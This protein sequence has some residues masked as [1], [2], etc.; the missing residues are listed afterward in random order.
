[1]NFKD[2]TQHFTAGLVGIYDPD[3]AIAIFSM[4]ASHVVGWDRGRLMFNALQEVP[5]A[6]YLSFLEILEEL[7]TGKPIQYVLGE[8]VF[9]G[10]K[11]KVSP[12]VLIPRPETEELVE[13]VIQ[14]A[15]SSDGMAGRSVQQMRIL[16]IGTGSGCIA[17][18]LKKQLPKAE[19]SALDVSESAIQI[20]S[21]NAFIN[22][23]VV[24]FIEADIR[25]YSTTG[26]F[27]I[28][29]SN[30]P[31]ITQK[32]KEEMQQNVLDHEPH[33][34]LFVTNE[35]PL[36]FYKAIADF[37]LSNL[38]P[39][40]KLFFEINEYLGQEMIAMLQDKSFKNI[41][42]RKDM[43]GKDRMIVCSL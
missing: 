7:K 21:A 38:A 33:L 11:F 40:G 12:A 19:V 39:E 23:V 36:V 15:G 3:E 35:D 16:D 10:L 31:Y 28:I 22:Q 41:V 1:M 6:E 18:S 17:V 8:T 30:P 24:H 34:A 32:E 26:K 2:L 29:V 42:L 4:A 13:W 27:D 37:A 9:Y 5:E 20:A 25:E 14:E 43:Q